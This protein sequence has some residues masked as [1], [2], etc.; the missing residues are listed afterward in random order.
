MV[1]SL[2][3]MGQSYNPVDRM[4]STGR[5]LQIQPVHKSRVQ[6]EVQQDGSIV[7]WLSAHRAAANA[8]AAAGQCAPDT[9]A[10]DLLADLQ[11]RT[12]ERAGELASIADEAR[13]QGSACE[14]LYE[15]GR[16]MTNALQW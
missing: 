12:D 1:V 4:E 2:A 9:S 14:L 3:T 13:Y 6:P 11:R 8:R 15:A 16:E 5:I 10:L 7:Y